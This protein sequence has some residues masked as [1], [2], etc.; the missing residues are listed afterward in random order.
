[1]PS[2]VRSTAPFQLESDATPTIR[3]KVAWQ[4][5]RHCWAIRAKVADESGKKTTKCWSLQVNSELPGDEYREERLRV[6]KQAVEKWNTTDIS[7]ASRLEVERL[8]EA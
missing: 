2:S 5:G 8:L 1:M 6:W 7:D 3:D 4:P